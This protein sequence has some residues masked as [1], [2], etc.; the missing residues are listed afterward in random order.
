MS[1][2]RS[3]CPTTR[4]IATRLA[5]A[6]DR[7]AASVLSPV[8]TQPLPL[9]A[10]IGASRRAT[11][12]RRGAANG[13][14]VADNVHREGGVPIALSPSAGPASVAEEVEEGRDRRAA[15]RAIAT[16]TQRRTE[17]RRLCCAVRVCRTSRCRLTR[18]HDRSIQS[19]SINQ[20]E[21]FSAESAV[22]SDYGW[23]SDALL[24]TSLQ[25]L[26]AFLRAVVRRLPWV[27][28]YELAGPPHTHGLPNAARCQRVRCAGQF[29]GTDGHTSKAES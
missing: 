19:G 7:C 24:R 20:F 25:I 4:C 3:R 23:D 9:L 12:E 21:P 8:S 6:C 22:N 10:R 1:E 11:A 14:W 29:R 15:H 27:A 18:A 16:A 28:R 2:R 26:A 13:A 17:P 5:S